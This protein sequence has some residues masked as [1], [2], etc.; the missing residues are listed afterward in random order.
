MKIDKGYSYLDKEEVF[1]E[2][3]SQYKPIDM[4]VNVRSNSVFIYFDVKSTKKGFDVFTPYKL[5]NSDIIQIAREILEGRGIRTDSIEVNTISLGR[6]E[7]EF[8]NIK[9]VWAEEQL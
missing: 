5:D 3:E 1:K 6:D 2:I 4:M 7:Y 8:K 9:F